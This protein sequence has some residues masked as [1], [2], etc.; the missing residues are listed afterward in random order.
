M[1]YDDGDTDE[2]LANEWRRARKEHKCYAC[3]EMIRRGDR[4]HF[5]AGVQ[6]GFYA[7]K[8]CARCWWMG[9]EIL[10]AGA[11]TWQFDLRCGVSWEEAFEGEPPSDVAALA[12][13]TPDEAQAMFRKPELPDNA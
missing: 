12:F 9:Q 5:T 13:L 2:P 7:I 6:D 4:Y 1:C 11:E 3:R 10:E 8:H